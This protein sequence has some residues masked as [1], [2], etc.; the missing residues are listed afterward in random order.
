MSAYIKRCVEHLNRMEATRISK[1]A[2][3]Y[4]PRGRRDLGATKLTM[5]AGTGH[6]PNL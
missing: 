3:Q 1:E 4:K 2:L 5:E 6:W